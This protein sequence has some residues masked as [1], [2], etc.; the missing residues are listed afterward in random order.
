M[1]DKPFSVGDY[2]KISNYE[3]GTVRYIGWRIT[4]V[5]LRNGR[6]LHVPNGVVTTATVTNF[7][8]K[9]H[10]Y[11][12]K[13]VG[14]RYQD[15]DNAGEVAKKIEDWVKSHSYT[16]QRRVSFAKLFDLSDSSVV[17]RVR[18]YL[19]SSINTTQW[20][21]FVEEMLLKINEIVKEE[22]ADFAFPTRTV[23]MENESPTE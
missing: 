15:I 1:V 16:N 5:Q 14:I 2:V 22:G 21:G 3:E 8:E 4:E 9:T 20:Y 18:A 12:Q 6:I 19:K 10:W 7:S 13:E 11:V 23:I 17:I